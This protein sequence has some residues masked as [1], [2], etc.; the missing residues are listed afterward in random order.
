MS[1]Y[2]QNYGITK[3]FIQ[4]PTKNIDN[5]QVIEWI[6]DYDGNNANI[7]VATN[8]NGHKENYNIQLDN[9][10]ILNLLKIPPVN[11]SLEQRLQHDFLYDRNY[12]IYLEGIFKRK[13]K[14]KKNYNNKKHKKNK[15][16]K[17]Y[18]KK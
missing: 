15:K 11:T 5:K 13:R 2:M 7:H 6:G 4:D 1:T 10:D 14:S 3:T 16:Y 12:P 18:K 9:N 8:N 17:T